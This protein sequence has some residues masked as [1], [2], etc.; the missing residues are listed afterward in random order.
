MRIAPFG[1]PVQYWQLHP[2][3]LLCSVYLQF[4]TKISGQ[5]IGPMLKGQ[6][7]KGWTLDS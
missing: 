1:A 7:S 5:L 4:L 2:S 6:E 3:G